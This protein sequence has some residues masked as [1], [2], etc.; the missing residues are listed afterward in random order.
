MFKLD[1]EKAE[2]PEIKLSRES[3]GIPE[4]ISTLASLTMLKPLSVS[5]FSPSICHEVMDRMS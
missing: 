5:T 1:L 4:K 2:E 3:K